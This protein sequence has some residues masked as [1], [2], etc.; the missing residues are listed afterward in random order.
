MS[1]RR[2]VLPRA[3]AVRPVDS[4]GRYGKKS[5]LQQA[6]NVWG[7]AESTHKMCL[8]PLR[9]KR[10]YAILDGM[11]WRWAGIPN[12]WADLSTGSPCRPL[13]KTAASSTQIID[14][15]VHIGTVKQI[16]RLSQ[17]FENSPARGLSSKSKP[18]IQPLH[19][20]D[21]RTDRSPQGFCSCP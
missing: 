3:S 11:P 19:P 1:R 9:L 6:N 13:A 12:T 7:L 20:T 21:L 14:G 18:L 17:R 2:V 8:W 15:R 5:P 16:R 4:L 10:F